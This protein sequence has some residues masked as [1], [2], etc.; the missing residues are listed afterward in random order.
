VPYVEKM[1]EMI[2][3]CMSVI[4]NANDKGFHP[5][6]RESLWKEELKERLEKGAGANLQV[7]E[8]SQSNYQRKILPW[9]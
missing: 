2:S 1:K 3:E 9:E 8:A 7:N 4:R 5:V 6:K